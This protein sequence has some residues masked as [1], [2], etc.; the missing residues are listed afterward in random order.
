ME[1]IRTGSPLTT[2]VWTQEQDMTAEAGG[3]AGPIPFHAFRRACGSFSYFYIEAL[4][5]RGGL[6]MKNATI[7]ILLAQCFSHNQKQVFTTKFKLRK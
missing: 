5:N 6:H 3:A 2:G 1:L 7:K 4:C